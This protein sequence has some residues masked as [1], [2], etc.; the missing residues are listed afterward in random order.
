MSLIAG[1]RRDEFWASGS[2][3]SN[4]WFHVWGQVHRPWQRCV[5]SVCTDTH[6]VSLGTSKIHWNKASGKTETKKPGWRKGY[7]RQ[8]HHSKMAGR[9]R[10]FYR[11]GNST[12][13]PAVAADPENLTLE[14][15]IT[16][17]GKLVTM[18]WPF[19]YTQDGR[20][21]PSW[22]LSN[23]K[24]RHLIRRPQKP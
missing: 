10:G 3:D 17:I 13:R 22:M 7:T 18:L 2:D 6:Y 12:M 23:R 15:N 8:H 16:P 4:D 19:L 1:V 24:L 5:S 14:A 11:T 21:P 20:L 9:H